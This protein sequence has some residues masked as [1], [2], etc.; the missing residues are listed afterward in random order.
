VS[1]P[2]I[3]AMKIMLLATASIA[4]LLSSMTSNAQISL[5]PDCTTSEKIQYSRS[6]RI[7]PVLSREQ[8]R[9]AVLVALGYSDLQV[10]WAKDT[11]S[12]QWFFE[13]ED[14][15]AMYAGYAVRNHYLQVAIFLEEDRLTTIVCDSRNLKQKSYSIHRKV[16]GWK[17]T[18]DDN[19]RLALGQASEY[20]RAQSEEDV[21]AEIATQLDNLE[22]LRR[23]GVL[24]DEEYRELR[25]RIIDEQ[26]R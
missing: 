25:S 22:S 20:F 9:E 8:A 6:S 7:P 5:P 4:L 15:F 10:S 14:E 17:G 24:T 23:S 3:D 19:L 13:F 16:P 2:E 26:T 11:F 18:L 21:A 1:I 12:G